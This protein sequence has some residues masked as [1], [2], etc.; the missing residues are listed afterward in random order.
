MSF[1]FKK[2]SLHLIMDETYIPSSHILS[3]PL[4]ANDDVFSDYTELPSKGF[5]RIFKAKRYGKWYVLKGLKPEFTGQTIY[6]ELLGKEFELGIQLDHPNIVNIIGKEKD[7]IVGDCIVMEYVDGYTLSVFLKTNPSKK[8]RDKIM[9]ELIGAMA[10][11]HSRQ[12]THRDLTLTNILITHNGY[13]VKIIDFG[14]SD[15]DY[16]AILKQPAGTIKYASPEQRVSGTII[17]CRSD[18]YAFGLI[19]KDLFPHKYRQVTRKCTQVD[20]N[21]RYDNVLAVLKDIDKTNL[22][23]TV[24]LIVA[25]ALLFLTAL[26]LLI[27]HNKQLFSPESSSQDT[28][29]LAQFTHKTDTIK[30][31]EHRSDTVLISEGTKPIQKVPDIIV[32]DSWEAKMIDRARLKADSIYKPVLDSCKRLK[33]RWKEE[34]IYRSNQ[35]Y[36]ETSKSLKDLKKEI[37]EDSYFVYNFENAAVIINFDQFK[38]CG[39]FQ[40]K[41]PSLYNE[42]DIESAG[43]TP[44]KARELKDEYTKS[45]K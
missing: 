33:Y 7:P 3:A 14:L 25:L 27:I 19:L 43:I 45:F 38:K 11:Y 42:K 22:R 37:P 40:E 5:N 18:I 39:P 26:F 2:V 20:R 32:P 13:N 31:I 16:H 15:T 8:T 29:P 28:V 23:K 17:D 24:L 41:L 35:V 44:E 36:W 21:K 34:L 10:Y 12:I 6:R 4:G 30:I 1:Y 9:R